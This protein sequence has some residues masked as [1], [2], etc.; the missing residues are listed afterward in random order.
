MNNKVTVV[1]PT[2]NSAKYIRETIESVQAQTYQNWEMV[3]VDDCSTDNTVEIVKDIIKSDSRIRIIEQEVNQGAAIA[4]NIAVQNSKGRFIAY[5]DSDDRWKKEKLEKQIKFMQDNDYGFSCTSY[6]VIDFEGKNLNK[7]VYMLNKVDYRGFLTNN[8]LQTV[9]IMIDTYKVDKKYL[10][11]PNIRRR[12]DAATWMQILKAGFLCYGLHEV[13][14]E[15]RRTP[16]SLSSNKIKAVMGTW[17]LYRE[18]ENLPL[19]LSCYCFIRYSILAIWKRLYKKNLSIFRGYKMN[20]DFIKQNIKHLVKHNIL[21]SKIYSYYKILKFTL[22]G[23]KLNKHIVLSNKIKSNGLNLYKRSTP[24]LHTQKIIITLTSYPKRINDVYFSLYSLLCQSFKPDKIILWLSLDEFPDKMKSLPQKLIELQKYG[25]TINWINT[26]YNSYDKII[27]ALKLFPNDIL[28][29][30]DDDIFYH[31]DW[32]KNLYNTY[33]DEQR[34][35]RK[36]IVCHRM[37]KITIKDGFPRPYNSWKQEIINNI[38]DPLN[39][40]TGCGG[41]LYPPHCFYKNVCH[42]DEFSEIAPFADD[43]WLWGMALLNNY[44]FITAKDTC[45]F[46]YIDIYR[47]CNSYDK[48]NLKYYNVTLSNNDKQ[49]YNLIKKYPLLL[50]IINN[51]IKQ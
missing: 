19:L 6:E 33:I 21:L 7:I 20:L 10:V 38:P 35:H 42:V 14:A 41:I 18:I 39:F 13:L 32:L 48:Q 43:I 4:R 29:T 1:T 36:T 31:R 46:K 50:D 25:L 49:M 8:L 5:L 16:N 24:P 12:Q 28:V 37:H 44:Y 45:K 17:K 27:H 40:P 26:T 11:M 47:E 23:K 30:A 34:K 51:N 2:W 22:Q 9:G 3:I 15:Y